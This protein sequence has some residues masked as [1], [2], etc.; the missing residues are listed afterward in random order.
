[1]DT[2]Y[3]GTRNVDRGDGGYVLIIESKDELEKLKDI[4]IDVK[5]AIPEY[6]DRIQCK[7][8][9]AFASSFILLGNDF[10]IVVVM[11]LDFLIDTN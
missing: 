6:T 7:V 11:P 4:H 2:G 10:G 9:Q 3:G 8:G 1:M 5:M